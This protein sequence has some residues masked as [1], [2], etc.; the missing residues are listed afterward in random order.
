MRAALLLLSLFLAVPASAGEEEPI[1]RP[2]LDRAA[3]A[4]GVTLNGQAFI[5]RG[6]VGAGELP[7]GTVDFLG[8]TLGSFS[9]LQIAPGSW[10]RVGDHYEGILWTLPD[11][12]RNDPAANLFF[13]YPARLVRLRIRFSPEKDQLALIPDGGL[14]LRDF[15]G[16][17]FTGADPGTG[18]LTQRGITLPAPASGVGKGKVSLDAESLQFT[19]DGGFYVGDEYTANV[20]FFDKRG[21]LRGVIQP[22]AAITPRQNGQPFF[23]SLQAPDSGRRN[24]QG[25]EGMSLSPDG[26]TLFVALQSALIQDSATGN[27]SGR[28]NTRVM[29]YDVSR[30]PTPDQPAAHYVVQLPAY[31]DEGN[32]GAPNRTAAQSE[33]RALDSHRFLMLARDGAGHGAENGKPIVYKSILLVD[34]TDATNLAGTAF[35]T[36]TASLL[37]NPAGT[38][39]RADIIPA[40]RAELVN[41]LNPVQLAQFGLS[42]EMLSEKWEAMDLVPVLERDSPADYFL[43]VGNDNDFIAR[44]CRMSGEA[45]D[46]RL[47]NDNRILVYRVS[48]PAPLR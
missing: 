2:H 26:R 44:N 21:R 36:G 17:P 29:V 1:S 23:G 33:I 15:R 30:T 3:G 47:D 39:L 25:A 41:M 24:N 28:V 20:Y 16:R 8:D 11:R 10:K 38:A 32:G 35:E 7:A 48:L 22:P 42:I 31:N 18:T 40:K 19:R 45:C 34:V 43:L 46:S 6:L 4:R 13:D 12:G 14:K 27:P 9:S 5:N 37:Q